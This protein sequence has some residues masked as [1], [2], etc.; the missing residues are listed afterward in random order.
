MRRWPA[1]VLVVALAGVA[2]A[3]RQNPGQLEDDDV[4][5]R[6]RSEDKAPC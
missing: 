6:K 1:I 4:I 2:A 5:D 3:Q